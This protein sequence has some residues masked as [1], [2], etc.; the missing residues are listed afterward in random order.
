MKGIPI[1]TLLT[2]PGGSVNKCSANGTLKEE[3]Q[4]KLQLTGRTSRACNAEV[5]GAERCSRW[6]G[7]RGSVRGIKYL[8]APLKTHSFSDLENLRQNQIEVRDTRHGHGISAQAAV[9]I[10]WLS[11]KC[12]RIEGLLHAPRY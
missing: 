12:S 1:P 7:E 6:S 9:R 2:N 4:P 10:E 8:E 3:L 5:A 11:F